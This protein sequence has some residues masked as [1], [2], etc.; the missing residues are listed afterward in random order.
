MDEKNDPKFAKELAYLADLYV[1]DAFGTTH[2][3]HASTES[4]ALHLK[5][6]VSSCKRF[7]FLASVNTIFSSYIIFIRK[8]SGVQDYVCLSH[9]H[10]STAFAH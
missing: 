4:V 7:G 3:A 9:L 6:L 10:F 2:T 1:N 5:P 8:L